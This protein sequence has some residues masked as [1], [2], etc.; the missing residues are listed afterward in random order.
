MRSLD[1]GGPEEEGGFCEAVKEP[2]SGGYCI[3]P[4]MANVDEAP[5]AGDEERDGEIADD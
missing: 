3:R 2:V 1:Q 4:I 5:S